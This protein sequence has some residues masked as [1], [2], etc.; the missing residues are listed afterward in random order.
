MSFG[1]IFLFTTAVA[2]AAPAAAGVVVVGDS[3]AR[4]C[5]EAAEADMP[6][7]QGQLENCNTALEG[8]SLT[9]YDT[10]ATHVNRGILLLRRGNVDAS[11]RDFDHAISLDPDQ[12]EA[13]LNKGAAL[14][15]AGQ[16][17][18]ALPL[19][20]VALEK[21]TQKPAIAYLGRGFAHEDLGDIRSAYLDYQRANQADP[22]W[23]IPVEEL[24]RFS[25][26]RR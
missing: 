19:F 6:P 15:R 21:N 24:S 1:K 25:I 2:F 23:N 5:Y 14:V 9:A 16:P 10:V 3:P 18:A 17:Q 22:K 8:T 11:I 7:S 20:S 12:P 13:Y 4:L 26:R